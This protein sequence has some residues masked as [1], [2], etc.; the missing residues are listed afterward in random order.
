M[1]HEVLLLDAAP[2]RAGQRLSVSAQNQGSAEDFHHTR[3]YVTT[4]LA[5]AR[6]TPL[7]KLPNNDCTQAPFRLELTLADDVLQYY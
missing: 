6:A 4:L 2:Y 5:H 1:L 7:G 3:L